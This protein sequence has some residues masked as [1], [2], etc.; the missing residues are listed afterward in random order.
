VRLCVVNCSVSA[1]LEAL[2]HTVLA[3]RPKPGVH[4]LPGLLARHGFT[5]EALIQQETLGPRILLQGLEDLDCPKIYWSIDTH[6]N[7][8]WQEEYAR[9]FDLTCSTQT[10]W[11]QY[12]QK[13]GIPRTTWLPWFGRRLPWTPWKM[14]TRDMAFVGRITRHR[15]T[16]QRFIQFLKLHFS[17]T[18]IQDVTFQEMVAIYQQTRLA[19]NESIFG[20]INFRLFEAASCGCLVLNQARIH[21]LEAAYTPQAEI[22]LYEHA[23]DLEAKIVHYLNHVQQAERMAKAAWAKTQESHLPVHRARSLIRLLD[24]EVVPGTCDAGRLA[25]RAWALT[26]YRLWQA[27]R[28]PLTDKGILK[29]LLDLPET[30]DKR[31]ALLGYWMG[32]QDQGLLAQDLACLLHGEN[33]VE[34][35]PVNAVGSLAALHIKDFATARGFWLRHARSLPHTPK[36]PG[37]ELEMYLFWSKYWRKMGRLA[38]PGLSFDP[39]RHLPESALECLIMAHRLNPRDM[40][41]CR[42]MDALLDGQSGFEPLRLSL[43]SHITLHQRQ[44]WLAGLKL[45]LVNLQGFRLEQGLEE[46][47]LARDHARRQGQEPKFFHALAVSDS[48]GLLCHAL[49]QQQTASAIQPA[50][51]HHA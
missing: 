24:Q 28:A 46:M 11:A 14:R 19:P 47:H 21:G 40:D 16:R 49:K 35:D 12:L 5:P 1:E 39:A 25:S 9:L 20:E 31:V 32:K 18:P 34:N 23:L 3:L 48:Q 42:N 7:A 33:S 50:P 43:L 29:L 27:N 13:I 10:Q 44:D 30:P 2:G 41:I 4:D 15:P 51:A 22:V 37:N 38:R 6:L 8:F 17:L 45:G 36:P 26:M